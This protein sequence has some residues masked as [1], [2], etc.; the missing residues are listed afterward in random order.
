MGWIGMSKSNCVRAIQLLWQPFE[1]GGHRRRKMDTFHHSSFQQ[2]VQELPEQIAV[3]LFW[4]LGMA[5]QT[6]ESTSKSYFWCNLTL[7]VPGLTHM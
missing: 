5:P 3:Q 7:Y 2:F 6:L 4:T 1:N